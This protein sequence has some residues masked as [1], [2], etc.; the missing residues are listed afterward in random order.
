MTF[1]PG[2]DLTIFQTLCEYANNYNT[3]AVIWRLRTRTYLYIVE[4]DQIISLG[5]MFALCFENVTLFECKKQL[6]V[7]YNDQQLF[8]SY[9]WF[10][11]VSKTFLQYPPFL[12]IPCGNQRI[13]VYLILVSK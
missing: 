3:K 1:R 2:I 12:N 5:C 11:I 13:W 4:Y 6:A 8:K 7:A 10:Q 9:H